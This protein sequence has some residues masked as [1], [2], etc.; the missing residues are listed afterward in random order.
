MTPSKL[1]VPEIASDPLTPVS[2]ASTCLSS[3][4]I[5]DPSRDPRG[6]PPASFGPV[7]VIP[8]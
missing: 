7:T 8:A 3:V 4:L 6:E 5:V 1:M 2:A